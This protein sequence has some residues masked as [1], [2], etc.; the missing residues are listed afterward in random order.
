[1]RTIW[2]PAVMSMI[3]SSSRT[4]RAPT[5]PPVLSVVFMVMMPLPPRVCCPV[6]VEAGAFA[7]A[8]LA[9][10]QQGGFGH[11]DGEGDDAVLSSS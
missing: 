2:P 1:M 3:S 10:D 7:D 9:G 5:T 8:V 11:D 6:L 4:V